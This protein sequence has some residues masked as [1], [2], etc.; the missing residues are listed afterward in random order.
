MSILGNPF[1][2]R[3]KVVVAIQAE[4]GDVLWIAGESEDFR[5]DWCRDFDLSVPIGS[6]RVIKREYAEFHAVIDVPKKGWQQGTPVWP[7]KEPS[8]L[9][10]GPKALP[11]GENC[12]N[13]EPDQPQE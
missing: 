9:A 2:K 7:E 4:S 5:I 11:S 3:A 1:G 12:G 6:P 8:Q 13:V 10:A